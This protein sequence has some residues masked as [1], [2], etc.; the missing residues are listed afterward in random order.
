LTAATISAELQHVNSR[1]P[2]CKMPKEL[3]DNSGGLVQPMFAL[4]EP[5]NL[6]LCSWSVRALNDGSRHFVGFTAPEGQGRVSSRIVNADKA[7]MRGQPE[8]GRVYQ[9]V[10]AQGT[11]AEAEAAWGGSCASNFV[12]SWRDASAELFC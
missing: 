2:C 5:P 6:Q 11:N 12:D 3:D 8:T 7:A 9:L 10:G 4:A 1:H